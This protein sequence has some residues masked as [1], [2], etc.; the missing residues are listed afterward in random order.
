MRDGDFIEAPEMGAAGEEAEDES[1]ALA[2]V[3]TDEP[4]APPELPQQGTTFEVAPAAGPPLTYQRL[5]GNR[6]PYHSGG[7]AA[8][9]A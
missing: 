1:S 4:P 2:P 6:E 9:S 8:A 5:T 3:A 7:S